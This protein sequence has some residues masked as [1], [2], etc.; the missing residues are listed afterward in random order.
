[1]KRSMLFWLAL[2]GVTFLALRRVNAASAVAWDGGSNVITSAGQLTEQL[3]KY[4]ALTT[5][6][7]KFG[8]NVRVIASTARSGY[9]AIA[10]ARRAHGH[11]QIIG[12][13]LGRGSQSEADRL[14]MEQCLKDGGVW[15]EV[16]WR[17]RG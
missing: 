15:P 3:A 14:A 17:I 12:I 9:G 11:G 4:D 8:A 1:M 16:R 6:R 10:V 7:Q 5:A 2:V 13:A